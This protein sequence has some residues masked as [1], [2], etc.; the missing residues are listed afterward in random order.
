MTAQR[1][2]LSV[3]FDGGA[4]ELLRRAYGVPRGTWVGTRLADP[5]PQ[6][7]A[8]MAAND[9]DWTGPDNASTPSAR[10]GLNARDR[11]TR[12]FVRAMYY[13]FRRVADPRADA[14][15]FDIGRRVVPRG[16]IPAGR[17]IRVR[18]RQGGRAAYQAGLRKGGRDTWIQADGQHGPRASEIE[19]R[20][21]Q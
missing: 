2:P 14:L 20:D 17:A 5:N 15:E 8:W 16:I 21:W 13:G 19:L 4:A 3:W 11:W 7:R 6:M 18:V 12:A 10:G 9:I 1:D